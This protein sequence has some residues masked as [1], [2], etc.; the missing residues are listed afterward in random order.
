M[1]A[2]KLSFFVFCCSFFH[3]LFYFSHL[4]CYFV[5]NLH[6]TQV[7]ENPTP[8]DIAGINNRF[9]RQVSAIGGEKSDWY[10]RLLSLIGKMLNKCFRTENLHRAIILISF[11]PCEVL[12][13]CVHPLSWGSKVTFYTDFKTQIYF[14]PRNNLLFITNLWYTWEVKDLV[15]VVV[16]EFIVVIEVRKMPLATSPDRSVLRLPVCLSHICLGSSLSN[17]RILWESVEDLPFHL[18][19]L[20]LFTCAC[21]RR[22]SFSA[23]TERTASKSGCLW[24]RQRVWMDSKWPTGPFIHRRVHKSDDI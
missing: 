12:T 18:S 1:E 22:S 2:F 16:V 11:N 23:H 20:S 24:I 6:I 14:A 10:W 19:L 17:Y 8:Y 7:N 9:N 15:V 13:F 21:R 4:S 5:F 3:V